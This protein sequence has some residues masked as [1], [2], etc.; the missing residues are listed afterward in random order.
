M[1]SMGE[2]NLILESQ[3]IGSTRSI[4]IILVSKIMSYIEFSMPANN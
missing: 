3:N 4:L 2:T 1:F